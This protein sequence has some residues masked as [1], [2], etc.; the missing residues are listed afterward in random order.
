MP[1]SAWVW[2]WRTSTG[3]QQKADTKQYKALMVRQQ[4]LT[5]EMSEAAARVEFYTKM[6]PKLNAMRSRLRVW[7]GLMPMRLPPM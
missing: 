5:L 1:W 3:R 4:K 2:K 6:A 7:C